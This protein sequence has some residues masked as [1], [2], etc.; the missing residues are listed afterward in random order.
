[1]A[2]K[3]FVMVHG[4]AGT[5]KS[6]RLAEF[7]TRLI[8]QG[9]SVNEIA[10]ISFTKKGTYRGVELIRDSLAKDGITVPEFKYFRTIHG[11]CYQLL[12]IQKGSITTGNDTKEIADMLG[13]TGKETHR[14]IVSDALIREGRQ[15]GD[16]YGQIIQSEN[17]SELY[18]AWKKNAGKIDFSDML[19]LVIERELCIPE[20]KYLFVD[21]VQDITVTQWEVIFNVFKQA[22]LI[23]LGGDINQFIYGWAGA[24]PDFITK[25][26][27]D[28]PKENQQ[29]LDTSYRCGQNILNASNRFI[30]MQTNA[31]NL[32]WKSAV[33]E[34]LVVYEE[35][36]ICKDKDVPTPYIDKV[37]DLQWL[38]FNAQ[39]D[40][41]DRY[42]STESEIEKQDIVAEY[43]LLLDRAVPTGMKRTYRDLYR[44]PTTFWLARS[45]HQIYC[46]FRPILINRGIPFLHYKSG[47]YQSF[48]NGHIQNRLMFIYSCHTDDDAW[49]AVFINTDSRKR[50]HMKYISQK[51]WCAKL[52]KE[53]PYLFN[54]GSRKKVLDSVAE[55]IIN[56]DKRLDEDQKKLAYNAYY[57]GTIIM[58]PDLNVCGAPY[59]LKGDEADHVVMDGSLTRPDRKIIEQRLSLR[60]Q[61]V[62]ATYVEI[63]RARE[64]VVIAHRA[65]FPLNPMLEDICTIE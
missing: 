34:G 17:F 11:I 15:D 35:N 28:I 26:I 22:E 7:V 2:N 62:K 16:G 60:E 58:P 64:F 43:S 25:L 57:K 40:F 61:I 33:G 48:L 4:S 3:Q 30:S 51:Q 32:A 65:G 23:T 19:R 10:F 49:E 53:V 42:E 52:K 13:Y 29:T 39:K 54:T 44:P 37:I 63:T 27:A 21:E 1:M 38:K 36:P 31:E 56:S 6:H 41:R 18:T 59:S 46:M 45:Q 47:L 24:S 50:E 14:N 8:K 20:V 5:G 55:H 12:E 9:V